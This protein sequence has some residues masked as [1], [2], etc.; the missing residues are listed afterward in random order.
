[1]A[2]RAWVVAVVGFFVMWLMFQVVGWVIGVIWGVWQQ[3][4]Q[5]TAGTMIEPPQDWKNMLNSLYSN[6]L[7][8]WNYLP[9]VV[10]LS[11]VVYIIIESLRRRPEEY[12]V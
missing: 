4:D 6:M 8:I 10:L 2:A 7:G 3:L 12:Y 11:A 5:A 9:V 1:M